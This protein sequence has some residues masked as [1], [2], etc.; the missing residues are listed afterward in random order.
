MMKSAI[1]LFIAA[2]L[3]IGATAQN[4]QEGVNN[5]YAERYQSAQSVFEKLL[6]ANPNNIDAVYWLGQTHI[7][8]N[9]ILA[10]KGI[11]EKALSTNGNAPLLLVGIG[12]VDLLEGRKPEARQRFESALTASKGRKGNDPTILNS[13]GRANVNA[14]TDKSKLGD[15]DYGIAKL[16]E[17]AQLAPNNPE[18]F[19]NLGNA[20]RKKH[21]GSEAV[22]A[23]RKAVNFAPALYRTAMLYKTQTNYRQPDAWSVVLDNLNNA[24]TADPRFAPAYEELYYYNLLAKKDFATAEGFANKYIT[25]SDQS[26]ENDYLR[27]QTLFVQNKFTEAINI[28]KDII[29]QTNN[30]PRPRVYRLMVYSYL[31]S[32]DTTTA[33]QF[34]NEF[35]AKADEEEILGQDYLAQASSCGK[36]NPELLR[37]AIIKA[38]SMDSVLSRQVGMLN[39]AAKDAKAAG[40]RLLEAELN[41]ISYRL[42]D[43]Q[44]NHTELINDISL[45][46]FFGGDYERADSAAKQYIAVAP[47]SIYGHYWSALAL[48]RLDPEMEKGLAMPAYQK[49]LDISMI[50]K[51][52]HRSQGVRAAQLLAIYSFNIKND[53]T[54]AMEFT[55]KG[56]EFDP[57]NANLLN[58]KNTLEAQS[59]SN[60]TAKPAPKTPVKK[61]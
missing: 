58:I 31:G 29:T 34:S 35:F 50:D 47:D 54:A 28:G 55:K 37:S 11:Y 22:Q 46:Y 53:K 3:T 38:V 56:L 17:A 42:R 13:V 41:V 6:A 24:I 25:S 10:A 8:Q 1:V 43:T 9:N 49:V 19:L 45:P 60:S 36:G 32:K 59:K 61:G 30:N 14:Y 33:C 21:N 12:H 7:A 48:E 26:P 5:L 4:I 15:L 18:I 52:R 44:V 20:Y 40:Q 2:F 57:E 51:E 23:Y 16:N 39:D 27:A